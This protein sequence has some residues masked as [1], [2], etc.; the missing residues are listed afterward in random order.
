MEKEV[1]T[2]QILHH[3]LSLDKACYIPWFSPDKSGDNMI[4]MLRIYSMDDFGNL[5]TENKF[6]IR[7][8]KSNDDREE[9]LESGT[10]RFLFL[11]NL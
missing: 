11:S 8:L 1:Q 7:Q 9:A 6:K 3:A 4:K 10:I 2:D 5:S